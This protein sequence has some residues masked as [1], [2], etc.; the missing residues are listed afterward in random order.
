VKIIKCFNGSNRIGQN[1]F[2]ENKIFNVKFYMVQVLQVS[3][4]Q[5]CIQARKNSRFDLNDL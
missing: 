2:S 5:F 3:A 1:I 4:F